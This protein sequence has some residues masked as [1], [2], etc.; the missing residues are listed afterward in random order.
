MPRNRAAHIWKTAVCKRQ[1]KNPVCQSII[2]MESTHVNEEIKQDGKTGNSIWRTEE[3]IS[4]EI[5]FVMY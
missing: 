3:R 1:Q 5:R 2:I 4:A